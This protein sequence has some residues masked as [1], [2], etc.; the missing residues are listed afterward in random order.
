[1]AKAQTQLPKDV[2]TLKLLLTTIIQKSMPEMKMRDKEW[3]LRELDHFKLDR[4]TGGRHQIK[5]TGIARKPD[6]LGRM[7]IPIELR[8]A[9]GIGPYDDVE[10]THDPENGWIM[11]EKK[12]DTC[13]FCGND[14]DLNKLNGKLLCED[15]V[16]KVVKG[17]FHA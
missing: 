11:L 13:T 16:A 8:R 3:C 15:C 2:E 5:A 6:K 12:I 17:E 10:I 4:I 14:Q 1:M 7:V 9:Y